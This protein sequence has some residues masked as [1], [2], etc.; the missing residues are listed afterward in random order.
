MKQYLERTALSLAL[1]LV[2]TASNYSGHVALGQNDSVIAGEQFAAKFSTL[3]AAVADAAASQTTLVISQPITA[4][5]TADYVIPATLNLK[6][7]GAGRLT[8]NGAFTV[9]V[10]API[11]DAPARRIFDGTATVRLTNTARIDVRW[12]GASAAIADNG[13]A[14]NRALVAVS[15]AAGKRGGVVWI[16]E[17]Y[18]FS[19]PINGDNLRNVTIKGV[20]SNSG[21]GSITG[22]LSRSALI[23]T[24]A[25]AG[26]AISLRSANSVTLTGLHIQYTNPEFNGSLITYR[27][28]PGR[29][30]DA[31][32]N[33]IEGCV[34]EGNHARGASVAT[35]AC[36]IDWDGSVVNTLRNSKLGLAQIGVWGQRAGGSGQS[37]AHTIDDNEFVELTTAAI[38]D[39]SEAWRITNNTFEGLRNSGTAGMSRAYK[40][41]NAAKNPVGIT[42][43]GNWFGD[44]FGLVAGALSDVWLELKNHRGTKITGNYF[45]QYAYGVRLAS[46][47][48]VEVSGNRFDN[49]GVDLGSPVDLNRGISVT[50][51]ATREL[52]GGVAVTNASQHEGIVA[53]GNFA[54]ENGFY[55]GVLTGN[56]RLRLLPEGELTT[57]DDAAIKG[58]RANHAGV[59]GVTKNAG[60][61]VTT[62]V[63]GV[64]GRAMLNGY[65]GSTARGGSFSASADGKPTNSIIIGADGAATVLS[66]ATGMTAI[67]VRGTATGGNAVGDSAIGVYGAATGANA[68]AGAFD[69]AVTINGALTATTI[70][71]AAG[72]LVAAITATTNWNPPAVASDGFVATTLTVAGAAIG[73]PVSAGFTSLDNANVTIHAHVSAANTVR[74]MI[75]NK[76]GASVD[77]AAGTLRVAVFKF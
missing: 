29:S 19:T 30:V 64:A 49:N 5:L 51:N 12:F 54:T 16:P 26:D 61:A 71:N 43:S 55:G 39:A 28:A 69:G 36:L 25:G 70:S 52:G 10:D 4:T 73:N 38:A 20:E 32:R 48:G 21:S 41:T 33:V 23:Y 58:E 34:I 77:L 3:Q 42:F 74:V 9:T 17:R 59:I 14:I 8:F 75:H 27:D 62:G 6:F 53:L 35:A 46:S 7:I 67:G 60:Q 68:R 57:T 44:G 47:W 11:L 50:G 24:G 63:A 22:T 2:S 13:A 56:A 76:T 45:G 31:T 66:S 65:S 18:T 37:N 40:D 72:A 1:L 15:A